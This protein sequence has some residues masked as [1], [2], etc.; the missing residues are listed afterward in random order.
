MN[1]AR[2]QRELAH[3]LGNVGVRRLEDF[4]LELRHG[5]AERIIE[6]SPA[7]GEQTAEVI[8]L[9]AR[10]GLTAIP[11][12]GRTFVDSGNLMTQADLIVSTRNMKR[13]LKHEPADLVATAEAGMTLR[14][15]QAQLA[16]AG[17]W[18]P[19]DPPDNGSITLGGAVATGSNGPQ[20]FGYGPLRSFVIG[21][22]AVLAEGKQIKAGGSVVKNVAGYDLCKL[23]TGSYGTLGIITELTFKLRPLPLETRTIVA[24]GSRDSL[25]ST[26]RSLASTF[27]PVAI[28]LISSKLAHDLAMQTKNEDVLLVK[29]TGSPRAVV[30]QTAQALK[31]LRDQRLK[32]STFDDDEALWQRLSAAPQKTENDLSWLARLRASEVPSFVNEVAALDEASHPAAQ[33]QAGLGNGRVRVLAKCPTYHQQAVRALERLRQKAENLGGSLVIEKA[34][35][36]FKR[37]FDSWG[38]F[39]STTELMKRIKAQLDPND[40]LSPGRLF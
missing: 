18:L 22:R 21:M 20:S 24:T 13:L 34:S 1:E 23:F 27:F 8:Q 12:G 25:L 30:T 35:A 7:S 6:L 38:S 2:I 14:D 32:C 9:A 29:F 31:I 15:F 16:Q 11:A 36:D 39:G 33:W 17:Q 10:E 3:L 28:E 26:G 4:T 40:L 19:I 37:E 5:R